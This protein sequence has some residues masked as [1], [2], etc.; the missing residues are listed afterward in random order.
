[1]LGVVKWGEWVFFAIIL[2][3]HIAHVFYWIEFHTFATFN[4]C[5]KYCRDIC[6]VD[7]LGSVEIL[8]SHYTVSNGSLGIVVG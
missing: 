1:M 3:D 6:T 4:H 7:G 8:S 2:A 5:I